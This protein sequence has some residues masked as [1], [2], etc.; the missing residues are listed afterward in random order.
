MGW[1]WKTTAK[2]FEVT[3][4][5]MQ[6]EGLKEYLEN[7][8]GDYLEKYALGRFTGPF[9]IYRAKNE[10]T[11]QFISELKSQ[12]LR[13]KIEDTKEVFKSSI[14]ESIDAIRYLSDGGSSPSVFIVPKFFIDSIAMTSVKSDLEGTA[15][16]EAAYTDSVLRNYFYQKLENTLQDHLKNA[17]PSPGRPLK[18][19]DDVYLVGVETGEEWL[20]EDPGTYSFLYVNSFDCNFINKKSDIEN[21][22]KNARRKRA[23]SQLADLHKQVNLYKDI[24][25]KYFSRKDW[26]DVKIEFF[27]QKL[28]YVSD[29]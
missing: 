26:H 2:T 11:R 7:Q 14:K 22:M 15:D 19:S 21:K 8:S 12:G 10:I 25:T 5:I 3:A 6:A 9:K 13:E 18:I 16:F 27:G 20:D 4:K 17:K 1:I 28:I 24:K 29:Y 23:N